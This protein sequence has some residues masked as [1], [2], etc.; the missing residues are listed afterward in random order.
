MSTDAQLPVKLKAT[1]NIPGADTPEAIDEHYFAVHVPALRTLPGLRRHAQLRYLSDARGGPP[2]WW[3]GDELWFADADAFAAAMASPE[4]EATRADGFADRVAGP[5]FDAFLVEEEFAPA[6]SEGA[7][8]VDGPP[9]V[10]ALTGV[11]QVPARQTPDEVD[12]V[13]LDVHVPNVR[14][15]PRLRLHTVMRA[16]DWPA[17][18]HARWWRSAE[19]RFDSTADFSAV[20]DSPEYDTIRHDGFNRSVCGPE[21]DIF[22]V[23]HEWRANGPQRLTSDARMTA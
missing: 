2:A 15:L 19:I 20:F 9:A 16:L 10:T 22:L 7:G 3:R 23:E 12:G 21:V 6:G 4:W 1:W 5:R 14:R 11:W 13:Y 8:P 17:G 18:D